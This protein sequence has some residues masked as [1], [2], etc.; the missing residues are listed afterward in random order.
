MPEVIEN[1]PKAEDFMETARSFGNYDLARALAD[2]IDNSITANATEININANFEDNEIRISDNGTGMDKDALI[3]AMRL[4]SKNPRD[5]RTQND[6]GRF[7][8]GL[9]TASFSQADKLTVL[10]NFKG[11]FCGAQWDLNNCENFTMAVFNEKETLARADTEI[12]T[13]SGTEVIWSDLSRMKKGSDELDLEKDF[14]NAVVSAVDELGIIFHRFLDEREAKSQKIHINVNGNKIEPRD[15]FCRSNQGTQRLKPTSETISGETIKFSPYILPYYSNLSVPEREQL[16]GKEGFV[17]NS[18]FY[19]Y[20]QKR[21]IIRGTWFKLIPYGELSKLARIMVDV[22][23]SL[24]EQWKITVDKSGAQ[25]PPA[26]RRRLSNWLDS[27]V[28]K[29]SKK[30]FKHKADN[31]TKPDLKPLWFLQR[32]RGK[33]HFEIDT[34]HPILKRFTDKLDREKQREFREITNLIQ[35][36]LPIHNVYSLM[37]DN[38]DSFVQG[39][40]DLPKPL[41]EMAKEISLSMKR[42]GNTDQEIRNYLTLI[43]PF[44]NF[45]QDVIRFLEDEKILRV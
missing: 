43:Q 42:K 41:L 33:E 24:D 32:D 20:R 16:G 7:G 11:K 3:A 1:I 36:C 35:H 6:L 12:K 26:L 19:I 34:Q 25:L 37:S 8:L 45:P 10:T 18:G 13:A 38:Q 22:P 2:I 5:D 23:N 30:V 27:V 14:N 4:G 44:S 21:L 29:R 9:K 31:E 39:Y 40:T 28:V 15:P 17:K